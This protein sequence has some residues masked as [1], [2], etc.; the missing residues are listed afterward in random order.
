MAPGAAVLADWPRHAPAA[1]PERRPN[2]T[3]TGGTRHAL[4]L[5]SPGQDRTCH[6][7]HGCVPRPCGGLLWDAPGSFPCSCRR[8][9]LLAHSFR[10]LLSLRIRVS[11]RNCPAC[12]CRAPL[13]LPLA[14]PW[15]QQG[16]DGPAWPGPA[17]TAQLCG[18]LRP[19]TRAGTPTW[20]RSSS[21]SWS[22]RSTWGR[23]RPRMESLTS[24]R[25]CTRRLRLAAGLAGL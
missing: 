2:N 23:S 1:E 20:A 22:S 16:P 3:H 8:L 6:V 13:P 21:Q 18:A 24:L 9:L 5:Q 7:R 10:Q 25:A 4:H 11:M 14:H 19:C 17:A 15:K 12:R